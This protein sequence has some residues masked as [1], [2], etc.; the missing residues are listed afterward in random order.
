MCGNILVSFL[1]TLIFTY[2]MQIV[3]SYDD[4]TIHLGRVDVAFE[5]TA[6]DGD[7]GGERTF[8]VDV[9]ACRGVKG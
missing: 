3:T 2:E 9:R 7:G 6:A 1:I 8:L 5:N 4:S